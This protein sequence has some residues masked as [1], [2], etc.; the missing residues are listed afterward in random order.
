MYG[1]EIYRGVMCHDN[2]KWCKIWRGINVPFQNWHEEFDELWPKRSKV[3]KMCTSILR[4]DTR[5]KSRLF[6]VNVFYAIMEDN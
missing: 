5:H 4:S 1:F 2:E 6:H 3:S